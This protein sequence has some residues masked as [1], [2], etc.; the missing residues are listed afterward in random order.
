M[1]KVIVGTVTAVVGSL[2]GV[3][4][5]LSG[6]PGSWETGHV[7]DMVTSASPDEELQRWRTGPVQLVVVDDVDA[8]R[9]SGTARRG[10]PCRVS[11]HRSQ[12]RGASSASMIA[13]MWVEVLMTSPGAP[14]HDPIASSWPAQTKK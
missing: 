7:R 14:F 5:L 1:A 10:A 6:R 11:F 4:H 9:G 2:C 3:D 8:R 13:K 12:G